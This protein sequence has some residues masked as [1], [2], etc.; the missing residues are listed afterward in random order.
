MTNEERTE[1]RL[2][3]LEATVADLQR[4]LAMVAPK[5]HCPGEQADPADA[6]HSRLQQGAGTRDR[7]LDSLS[8]AYPL[9]TRSYSA[10]QS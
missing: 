1:Q 7:G 10:K 5:Q 6:Q 8:R 3:A 9:R 4:Q 2:A